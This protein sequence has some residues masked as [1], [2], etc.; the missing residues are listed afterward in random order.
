MERVSRGGFGAW[1]PRYLGLVISH[2]AAATQLVTLAAALA[3]LALPSGAFG[4]AGSERL[5]GFTEERSAEQLEAED[6]FQ[7][8]I[9]ARR[10]G[11][12]SRTLS[13]RPQLIGSPGLADSL[14]YSVDR[15]SSYGLSVDTAPYDVYISRPESI[16][17]TMTAPYFHRVREQGAALSVAAVLR[18]GRG[19]LQRLL[20]LRRRAR[21]GGLRQ[22]RPARGLR[23]AGRAGRGRRGQDRA[24]PL[25]RELPRGQGQGRRGAGRP[26]ADH[27]LRPR[28]GRLR[29]GAGLSQR[30][31]ALAPG[32]PARQHPVHLRVPG[33]PAHR[34]PALDPGHPAHRARG[35][36]EPPRASPPRRSP[37]A[38][39]AG[40]CASYAVPRGPRASRAGF[41]S[42]TAS[43]PAPPGRG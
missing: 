40:C 21:T 20:A 7:R 3:S 32:N 39:P 18:R 15:L 9:S 29:Q 5:P 6:R 14:D 1:R 43:A 25:R 41:P 42:P 17:V 12:I 8:A 38:T 35:R 37:T 23:G 34:G 19:G 27:L 2:R 36:G 10:A 11:R 13:G 4:Q 26:R 16:D 33:R 28:A 31:V 24:G 30:A 22:L